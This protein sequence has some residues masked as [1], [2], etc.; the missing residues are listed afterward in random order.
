MQPQAHSDPG[1]AGL[2]EAADG[3]WLWELMQQWQGQLLLLL[4]LP[5]AASPSVPAAA[6]T[7]V[8]RYRC[9]ANTQY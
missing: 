8:A 9:L 7:P 5:P 3:H 1:P 2:P 4:L 6:Q